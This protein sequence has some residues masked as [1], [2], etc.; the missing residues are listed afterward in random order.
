MKFGMKLKNPA[1][2]R[3]DFLFLKQLLIFC[4]SI[5]CK[6]CVV[7]DANLHKFWKQFTTTT[8]AVAIKMVLFPMQI[9]TNFESNSQ[10]M[11]VQHFFNVVVSDAN[12]HKFW[13]QFTTSM[14]CRDWVWRCF[15]CKFTQI[16]KAIHN[17]YAQNTAAVMLFPMQIYTNFE[18][19]SQLKLY[20]NGEE[21]GCFRCKFT[22]ILKA[23]HNQ[24][25]FDIAGT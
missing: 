2:W 4:K 18:S 21:V 17:Y 6:D 10:H 11:L 22:Q 20:L 8:A 16:L 23:I 7:S 25:E 19:N 12:L 1:C 15:R 3:S 5:I 13:K 24:I 9:Y 14:L